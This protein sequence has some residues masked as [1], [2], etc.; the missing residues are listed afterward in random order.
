MK[1]NENGFG[2]VGILCVVVLLCA[3][4][5]VGYRVVSSKNKS[6]DSSKNSQSSDQNLPLATLNDVDTSNW[7]SFKSDTYGISFK[8]PEN[9]KAEDLP[10]ANNYPG[11]VISSSERKIGDKS[12][13]FSIL[14]RTSKVKEQTNYFFD[15]NDIGSLAKCTDYA[16]I[17]IS[18]KDYKF[19]LS[20]FTVNSGKGVTDSYKN[21]QDY[22]HVY[23]ADGGCVAP[24]YTDSTYSIK[25]NV[26]VKNSDFVFTASAHYDTAPPSTRGRMSTTMTATKEEIENFKDINYLAAILKSIEAGQ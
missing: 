7:K 12:G 14:I 6:T 16:P 1:K 3:I 18:G 20:I 17:S 5:A 4:G 10:L 2:L 19:V 21:R 8:V 26:G 23:V 13:V 15:A 25:P 9:W 22:D 24:R 11:V